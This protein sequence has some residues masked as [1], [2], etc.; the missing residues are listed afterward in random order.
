MKGLPLCTR[1]AALAVVLL[2]APAAAVAQTPAPAR[3][4]DI[5]D[6]RDHQPTAAQVQQNAKAAGVARHNPREIR[7]RPRWTIFINN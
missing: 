2:A 3:E 5:W 4:G 6:W 7:R 1:A